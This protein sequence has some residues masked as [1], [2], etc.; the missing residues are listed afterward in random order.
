ME[1]SSGNGL[2][3]SPAC[4]RLLFIAILFCGNL[5]LWI[6]PGAD[7]PNAWG[8][9]GRWITDGIAPLDG[10]RSA[11]GEIGAPPEAT[12]APLITF[13]GEII[14]RIFGVGIGSARIL[15]GGATLLL[16]L[17]MALTLRRRFGDS[18]A[19]LGAALAIFHG[20]SFALARTP[21]MIPVAT[22]AIVLLLT[23]GALRGRWWPWIAF[24]LVPAGALLIH[25]TVVIAAVPLLVEGLGRVAL[26]RRILAHTPFPAAAIACAAGV[27]AWISLPFEARSTLLALLTGVPEAAGPPL[28][29]AAPALLPVAWCGFLIFFLH[30]EASRGTGRSLERSLH[31]AVWIHL[32]LRSTSVVGSAAEFAELIPLLGWLAV[33]AAARAAPS[34]RRRLLPLHGTRGAFV[35]FVGVLGT[36][37]IAF[38]A[39]ALLQDGDLGAVL[40]L[41]TAG[42]VTV[43]L[44]GLPSSRRLGRAA[45]TAV[46]W[47]IL[48]VPG[49]WQT[50]LILGHPPPHDRSGERP[51]RSAAPPDRLSRGTLG[52][53]AHPRQRP[54]LGVV[55][56][57]RSGETHLLHPPEATA[58]LAR[59]ESALGP[60]G[61]AVSLAARSPARGLQR[62]R[63]GTNRRDELTW[64]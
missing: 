5:V 30:A 43:L 45:A 44:F 19:L 51:P 47:P 50:V 40:G 6:Q 2:R 23:L 29:A 54:L 52:T 56:D 57:D 60:R 53:G 17:W 41:G 20:A 4:T 49:L 22:L 55:S 46:I 15:T 8:F 38:E 48:L 35:S 12:G 62:L 13:L 32:A 7:P 37:W 26:V 61:P 27:A 9:E 25:R 58:G 21:S 63:N 28:L 24:L 31:G 33:A 42:I 11:S 1:V 34:P 14:F 64:T 18:A 16:A 10:A 36:L 3:W 59:G 39:R